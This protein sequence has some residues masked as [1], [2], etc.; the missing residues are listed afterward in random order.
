MNNFWKWGQ[1]NTRTHIK[2]KKL[3]KIIKTC[4]KKSY[5]WDKNRFFENQ[6][7]SKCKVMK[8]ILGKKRQ[9]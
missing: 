5:Y 3:S 2:H 8:E 1:W 6:I 7:Q 4:V 9:Y